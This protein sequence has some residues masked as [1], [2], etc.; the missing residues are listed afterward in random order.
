MMSRSLANLEAAKRSPLSMSV[1][2]A[3]SDKGN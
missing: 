3:L 1:F 2:Y